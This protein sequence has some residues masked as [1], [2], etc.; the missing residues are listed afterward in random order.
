MANL[1]ISKVVGYNKINS[2]QGIFDGDGHTLTLNGDDFGT[3]GYYTSFHVCAPFRYVAG[4]TIKNLKVAGDIYTKTKFAGGL[5]GRAGDGDNV[6]QN[7]QNGNSIQASVPVYLRGDFNTD[8]RIQAIDANQTLIVYLDQILENYETPVS[9]I[10][11]HLIDVDSDGQITARD[12]MFILTY[13]I[14]SD[15]F[16]TAP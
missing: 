11:A 7:Y 8:G 10:Q 9:D 13:F 6:I 1:T 5:I 2:F 12:A 16:G 3:S 15:L 4:T 14:E